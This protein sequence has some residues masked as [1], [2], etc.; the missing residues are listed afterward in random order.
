MTPQERET[1]G[2]APDMNCKLMGFIAPDGFQYISSYP[3]LAIRPEWTV[4]PVARER[5]AGTRRHV[6][7]KDF[8][9]AR[10]DEEKAEYVFD[11]D[12]PVDEYAMIPGVPLPGYRTDLAK[13]VL[14]GLVSTEAVEREFGA[15]DNATWAL[16]LG[17]QTAHAPEVLV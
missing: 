2:L 12:T 3:D 7:A 17:K 15:A 4:I 5:I 9:E 6:S 8:P 16:R 13:L 14:A 1:L 11:S 10:W